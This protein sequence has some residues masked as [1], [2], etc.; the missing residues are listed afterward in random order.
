[1]EKV[2]EKVE[3]LLL[4]FS[5]SMTKVSRRKASVSKLTLEVEEM[6]DGSMVFLEKL[7][8]SKKRIRVYTKRLNG[9]RGYCDGFMK[10]FDKHFNLILNDVDEKYGR[11]E[12][13]NIDLLEKEDNRT[14]QEIDLA[15][16][17]LPVEP[18]KNAPKKNPSLTYAS[19]HCIV[20]RSRYVHQMILRGDSIVSVMFA[21]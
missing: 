6:K 11:L 1:M 7:L 18:I 2:K 16:L 17:H 8:L 10:A 21:P 20:W 12:I 5:T 14:R 15:G 4:G 9:I 3:T 13:Q 19:K